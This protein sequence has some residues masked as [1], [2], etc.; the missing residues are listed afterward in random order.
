MK[1]ALIC[2]KYSLDRGGLERY[3]VLLSRQLVR[4]GHEV[5]IFANMW[6]EEPG[7]HIHRVPMLHISSPIKNLSFAFFSTKL[8]S[9]N[10][11][12][13]IHSMERIFSQDIFRVSDGINPIQL[14]QRYPNP[15]VRCFKAMGPRRLA[16]RYL[17]HK[18]F[19]DRGCK[20]I[21]TNSKLVKKQ[22][23]QYYK[24]D[25]KRIKV[26]YNGVNTSI[27]YPGVKEKYGTMVRNKYAIREDEL[28][29]LFISNDFRLK[30]LKAILNALLL[31]NN[32]QIRLLVVGNDR[33]NPYKRW[34][35][36]SFL[37]KQVLFLGPKNDIEKY[38]AA[39]DI[40]CLPTLYD[41]FAN[42]CLEA[43]ACGLPVIT[44]DMNGSSEL[45]S[46][47]ENG[48]V[49]KTRQPEELADKI[50]I[51]S[52]FKERCRIGG[53]AALIANNFTMEKHIANILKLYELL[54][55]K[56]NI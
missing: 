55:S 37:D 3:T 11:F 26:I 48:F 4:A 21:M 32:K 31:L 19:E 41:A 12:S 10:D 53:N 39:S 1:I 56:K 17:E 44:T 34:A 36:K 18:I 42:V 28:V 52:S 13:V 8:L 35:K 27:F 15:A 14:L 25:E 5:H 49:I 47:G 51:L 24:V 20:I 7:I 30:G 6:Q 33:S 9:M 23:I 40:F 50:A 29:I 16:L 46:D 45:I 43:M 2:K 54:S 22:I 38:Y